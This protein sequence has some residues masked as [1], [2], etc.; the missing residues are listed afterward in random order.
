MKKFSDAITVAVFFIMLAMFAVSL[1]F[2]QHKA[3]FEEESLSHSEMSDAVNGFVK[4]NFP[5]SA[6]WRSLYANINVTL[7]KR[8]FGDVYIVGDRL[9]KTSETVEEKRFEKNIGRINDFAETTSVPVYVMIAPTASG[10]YSSELPPTAVKTDQRELIDKL[11]LGLDN[12]VGTIDAYYPLY[13][14][15]DEYVYYRTSDMWTSFGAYH[16]YAEAVKKLG[17]KAVTLQNY[18]QE[19]ALSSYTGEL[20]DRVMYGGITQDRINIF[21]S[22]YQSP[23]TKVELYDGENT[24]EAKSVYFKSALKT[25]N[26]T[27]VFLQG[28]NY[29]RASV[30]TNLEDAPKLLIIK[31]SYANTVAPFF[32]PHYSEITLADPELI[33]EKG[34]KLSDFVNVSDYDQ[35]LVMFDIQSFCQADCFDVLCS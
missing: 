1:M 13:S 35:V 30:K 20:Y 29:L 25:D 31:G 9:I 10:V 18:D 16:A 8:Q 5:L 3:T 14:S 19:Y 4:D 11:Y 27:D 17:F 6:N 32:T 26:E 28:D 7:G 22:K 33:K 15:R 12:G 2:F 24:T 34:G 23:V 21:R